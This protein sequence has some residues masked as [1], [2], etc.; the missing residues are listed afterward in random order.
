MSVIP[1]IRMLQED[2]HKFETN[3]GCIT[4][5]DKQGYIERSCLTKAKLIK[6]KINNSSRIMFYIL[7][8][9]NSFHQFFLY[10]FEGTQT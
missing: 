5:L 9:N 7:Y 6:N 2:C 4:S 1:P 10:I 3:L 8:N